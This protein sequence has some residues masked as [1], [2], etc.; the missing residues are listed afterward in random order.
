MVEVILRAAAEKEFVAEDN[1]VRV[2]D[3]LASQKFLQVFTLL[4][5]EHGYGTVLSEGDLQQTQ[6]IQLTRT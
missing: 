6:E 4:P 5:K 1:A 3:W 2:E